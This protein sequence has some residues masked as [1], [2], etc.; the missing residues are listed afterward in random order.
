MP[1]EERVTLRDKNWQA[2][3]DMYKGI[4]VLCLKPASGVHEIVPRSKLPAGW[5]E[6]D[7]RVPLCSE[8]HE[9]VQGNPAG[10]EKKLRLQRDY[11]MQVLHDD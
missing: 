6:I 8:C 10:W 1:S 4:C 9:K 3:W 2:V 5:N 7:N 11:L